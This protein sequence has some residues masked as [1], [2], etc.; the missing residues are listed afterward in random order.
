MSAPVVVHGDRL[1]LARLFAEMEF[2]VGAEIG[3]AAG[4]Y[5]YSICK[6]IPGVK[7]YCVDA[8]MEYDGYVDYNAEQMVKNYLTAKRRLEPFDV[9]LIRSYSMDA[10]KLFDDGE[11]DFVYIDANHEWPYIAQ[12]LYY[13][14]RK[15]RQGGIIS[16]HD[17][18]EELR[19]DGKC[20]V[21]SALMGYTE[22]FEIGEWYVLSMDDGRAGNWY[23]VKQ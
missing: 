2:R 6:A 19:P 9:E 15:V 11:L 14:D 21:K 10:V 20:H 5:A 3:T 12:D 17:Y 8:W 7:L 18:T 13:W 22:A 23:W 1:T 16:G 4:D